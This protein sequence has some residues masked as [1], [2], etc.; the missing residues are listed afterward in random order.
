MLLNSK[1]SIGELIKNNQVILCGNGDI[2]KANVDVIKEIVH[3]GL[4][5][6]SDMETEMIQEGSVRGD[7]VG[8]NIFVD[9]LN[10]NEMITKD[11]IEFSSMINRDINRMRLNDLR[12]GYMLNDVEMQNKV[13]EVLNKWLVQ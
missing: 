1:Q 2:I 4:A 7:L 12:S 5:V 9:Q 8:L 10:A 3:I 11:M 13:M 6:H